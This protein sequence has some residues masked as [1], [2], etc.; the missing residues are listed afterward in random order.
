MAF[1]KRGSRALPTA[2]PPERPNIHRDAATSR[3][4]GILW[5]HYRFYGAR[6]GVGSNAPEP[7]GCGSTNTA[8]G[9][10]PL[11]SARDTDCVSEPFGNPYSLLGWQDQM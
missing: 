9:L 5:K 8:R 2:Q 6:G 10:Q 3:K 1:E 7:A 4:F 11:V